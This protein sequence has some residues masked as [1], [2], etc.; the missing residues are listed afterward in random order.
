MKQKRMLEDLSLPLEME[1]MLR[2]MLRLCKL[3]LV[4]LVL[5]LLMLL[6]RLLLMLRLMLLVL[7]M[8]LLLVMLL[9]LWLVPVLVL[10]PRLLLVMLLLLTVLALVRVLVLALVRVPEHSAST[11]PSELGVVPES[12]LPLCLGVLLCKVLSLRLLL[13][14]LLPRAPL[15]SLLALALGRLLVLLPM[16]QH[17]SGPLRRETGGLL[18][19]VHPLRSG[20]RMLCV[21]S[22]L[23]R[24]K[25]LWVV[26]LCVF[27]A[28]L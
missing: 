9:V 6:L 3:V 26:C 28:T 4:F 24:R 27:G 16:Q 2:L 14:P 20:W 22:R 18:C 15:P 5:V 13:L 17:Q 19:V 21:L 8:V 23:V 1:L 7:L 25:S 11:M 12:E 10:V